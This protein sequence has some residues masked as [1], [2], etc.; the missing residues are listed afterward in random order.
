LWF[1]NFGLQFGAPDVDV[2]RRLD[3]DLDPSAL[4]AEDR[5][6]HVLSDPEAFVDLAAED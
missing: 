2:G 4:D 1:G 5:Y 3:T 6:E